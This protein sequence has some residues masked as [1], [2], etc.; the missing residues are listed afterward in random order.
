MNVDIFLPYRGLVYKTFAEWINLP[1]MASV[2]LA[3]SNLFVRCAQR[4]QQILLLAPFAWGTVLKH[5][6]GDIC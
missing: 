6:T 1:S 4:L 3:H 5:L 2:C